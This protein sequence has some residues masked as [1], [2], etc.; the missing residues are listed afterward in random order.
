MASLRGRRLAAEREQRYWWPEP[1]SFRAYF[2][3][4]RGR[5]I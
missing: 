1:S 5:E 3:V 4:R 2:I